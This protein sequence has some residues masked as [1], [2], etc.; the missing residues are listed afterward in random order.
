MICVPDLARAMEAYARIG[1]SIHPGGVHPGK[2]TQNAI[3]FNQADYLELLAI[4]D[5][6]EYV[7]GSPWPGLL[8]FIDAGGGLRYVILQSDDLAA[9]VA[10]MRSR[11][12][13]IG[14]A[15]EGGRRTPA[16][17]DLRWKAAVLGKRDP[18]P[19]F[20]I[21]HLTPLAERRRQVPDSPH[22]NGVTHVERVYVVVSDLSAAVP[23]YS[24]VLGISPK[25]E[26]GT[27]INADMAVYQLGSNGLVVAQ[28]AGP[29]VAADALKNRGPGPFQILYRTASMDAAARWMAD[30]GVPPPA[31]GVRNTGEQAMVVVPG[32]ACGVAVGFVGAA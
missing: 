6:A 14:D 32:Y 21:Q 11:G 30:H 19:L 15:A 12:V 23:A 5:R 7:A 22:P 24:R 20:F 2:G 3:A 16:G 26:R 8:D 29:G 9:D 10:A 4:R 25:M 27:V 1:F 31:R 18:L 17:Q 28:P 13:D